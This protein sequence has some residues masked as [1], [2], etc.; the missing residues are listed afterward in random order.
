M[1]S[2]RQFADRQLPAPNYRTVK[3]RADGLD[4]RLVM[5][6]R[7]GSKKA[8]EKF[9]PVNISTLRPELPLG[10]WQMD[11]TPVD[12]F[13]VDNEHSI[14]IGRPWLTLA[15]DLA[16]RKVAGIDVSLRAPSALSV[17][18]TLSH[19]VLSKTEWFADRKLLN[20]N[21]PVAGLPRTIHADN[22]KDFHSEALVRGCREY[23]IQL[24]H[25]QM[26]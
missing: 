22:G 8:R 14:L 16:A 7:E 13:V 11:H 10:V 19:A 5:R 9:G 12:V 26:P 25:R 17:S 21:W 4:F 24:D 1:T 3:R 18:L 6:K 23:G 15:I 2:R 20:L